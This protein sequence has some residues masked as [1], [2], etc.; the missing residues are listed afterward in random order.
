MN[1]VN[2]I[3][4]AGLEKQIATRRRNQVARKKLFLKHYEKSAN[5]ISRAAKQIGIN[6]ETFYE[7]YNTDKV[8][9]KA[10][11][12]INE[13]LIDNAESILSKNIKAGKEAS[14][15]FFLCNKGKKRLWQ[16]IQH[17]M[18]DYMGEQ[19]I[20][21]RYVNSNTIGGDAAGTT[22]ANRSLPGGESD[23]VSGVEPK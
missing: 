5:N 4:Q 7:W 8:F 22:P 10:V 16:S 21:V 9:A 19:E 14:L 23:A 2:P 18:N 3:K 1:N 11:D 12:D 13:S 17:V 15:F 20:R 6:R